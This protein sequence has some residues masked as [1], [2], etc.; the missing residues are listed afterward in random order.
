ML[1]FQYGKIKLLIFI[2]CRIS[3]K[4]NQMFGNEIEKE[5]AEEFPWVLF[6]YAF[7]FD[8]KFFK[9]STVF[10]KES[11]IRPEN[12]R[13]EIL[14]HN[15]AS[16]GYTACLRHCL[17]YTF[18]FYFTRFQTYQELAVSLHLPPCGAEGSK[19]FARLNTSQIHTTL[20]SNICKVTKKWINLWKFSLFFFQVQCKRDMF[21]SHQPLMKNDCIIW[22]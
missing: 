16:D 17:F 14:K 2:I 6:C 15:N 10:L 4:C 18:F 12:L 19:H 13:M 5:I 11:D 1:R 7:I 9:A 21:A 22:E 3:L 8:T 20:V